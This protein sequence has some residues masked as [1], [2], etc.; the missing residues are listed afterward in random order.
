MACPLSVRGNDISPC[1]GRERPFSLKST[2]TFL[3]KALELVTK[4]SIPVTDIAVRSLVFECHPGAKRVTPVLRN[5][6]PN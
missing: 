5:F 1:L 3:T 2:L 4:E 6:L